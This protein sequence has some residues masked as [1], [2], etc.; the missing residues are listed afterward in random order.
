MTTLPIR[1]LHMPQIRIPGLA[2]FIAVVSVVIE[3]YS[4]ALIKAREAERLYP[5][6]SE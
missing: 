4:E 6:A 5:Y 3:V 1:A 2:R